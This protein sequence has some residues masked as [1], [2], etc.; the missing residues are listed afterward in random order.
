M[1]RQIVEELYAA[2]KYTS[3]T[4]YY[5]SMSDTRYDYIHL[6]A[7]FSYTKIGFPQ[8]ALCAFSNVNNEIKKLYNEKIKRYVGLCHYCLGEYDNSLNNFQSISHESEAQSWLALLFPDSQEIRATNFM[9][10]HFVDCFDELEKKL[11]IFNYLRSFHYIRDYL[12]GI[13]LPKKIDIYIYR[14]N[15]DSLGNSLSYADTGLKSIH[16]HYQDYPGHEIAH[17]LFN[18][19][20]PFVRQYAFINEGLAVYFEQ[21]QTYNEFLSTHH[22]TIRI[23]SIFSLWQISSRLPSED[24]NLAGA[25]IGYLINQYENSLFIDFIKDPSLNRA[26]TIFPHFYETVCDFYKSVLNFM[27]DENYG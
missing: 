15:I 12:G 4:K 3:L 17:I 24:Y 2:K 18:L 21:T 26:E 9:N 19:K 25:F 10:F 6:L 1:K 23:K 8:K 22:K 5:E 7:G 20:Y 16:V 11:L 14:R 13:Y 27:K